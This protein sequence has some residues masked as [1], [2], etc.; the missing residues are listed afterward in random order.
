MAQIG[1]IVQIHDASVRPINA[2]GRFGVCINSRYEKGETGKY[3]LLTQWFL[4][5]TNEIHFVGFRGNIFPF[6]KVGESER[7]RKMFMFAK[8]DDI[9]N[10][11]HLS[12]KEKEELEGILC[13]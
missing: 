1:D 4:V 11:F 9:V 12:E 7:L 6:E 5:P 2:D 13:K 10:E 3:D 8:I